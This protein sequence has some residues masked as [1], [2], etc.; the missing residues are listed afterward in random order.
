MRRR[1]FVK[2]MVAASVTAKTGLGQQTTP[3][4]ASATPAAPIAPG[5]VPWMEGLMRVQPLPVL[6]LVPDAVAQGEARFF[7]DRQ[8]AT[9]R[10]LSEILVPPFRGYPGAIGAGTPEFLDFLIGISPPDRQQMYQSGLDRLDA[11]AQQQFHR[12]FADVSLAQADQLL[13]PRLKTWMQDHPPAEPYERFI[14]VAHSDIRTATLNSEAWSKAA[15]AVG[16]P[17]PNVG[18]YWSPVDPDLH[19]E[20][21]SSAKQR[22]PE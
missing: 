21:P 12:P 6:P 1:D 10:R 18:L 13:R 8:T 14:N 11:E 17:T 3:L 7:N 15:K 22:S 5:P 19:R 4:A 16:Q 9:L 2:A 20:N